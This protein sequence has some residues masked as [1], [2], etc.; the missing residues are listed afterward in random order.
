MIND[1]LVEVT[2]G[3]LDLTL[4]GGGVSHGTF[5]GALGT[6]LELYGDDFRAL[7]E[8]AAESSIDGDQVNVQNAR[9]TGTYR[10]RT[11]TAGANVRFTG[12]VLS[13]GATLG[14]GGGGF[15]Y[16]PVRLPAATVFLQRLDLGPGGSLTS[17]ADFEVSEVFNWDGV[18]NVTGMLCLGPD[19]TTRISGSDT[20]TLDRANICNEGLVIWTGTGNIVAINGGLF[21]NRATG[22]FDIRN[23]QIFDYG[24]KGDILLFRNT[25]LIKKVQGGGV[26]SF[27]VTVSSLPGRQHVQV[28]SGT[29]LGV[30]QA[31]FDTT[32]SNDQATAQATALNQP[33]QTRPSRRR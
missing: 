29:V 21:D 14:I 27:T 25:G 23:N 1:G 28:D 31:D 9:V 26:T 10:A 15:T 3:E 18:M 17:A 7:H 20:K 11:S 8:M 32:D 22:T 4:V 30:D 33:D 24:N 13:F 19:S 5:K 16:A 2:Q 12:T 6:R